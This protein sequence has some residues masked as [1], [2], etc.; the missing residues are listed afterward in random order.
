MNGGRLL[1]ILILLV[2]LLGSLISGAPIY[3]RLTYL[4]VLVVGVSWLWSRVSLRGIEFKRY[5]R[6]LR[7]S[8]GDVF[9]ERFEVKNESRLTCL[10]LEV[11]N[12]SQIPNA[13][14]S[15]IL[16]R[17]GGRQERSYLARTWL[18]LRGSFFLGPT[19]LTSGDPFG[20]FRTHKRLL[21]GESLVVMP[22]IVDLSSFLSPPGLLPGGRVIRRKSLDVT[23][24]ASGVREYIPGDPMKRIHWPTTVRRQQ[25][26]VKEF[27]QD[28]QAEVWLFLD[29]QAAVH[30]EKEYRP[31]D[32][33][34]DDWLFN[35]KPAFKLPPSTLEY[36][37]S[38]A[39]SLAHYFIRQKRAVGL[40]VAG[41]VQTIIPAERSWRQED[42]ILE[43]LA[44]LQATGEL[45][46]GSLVSAQAQQLPQGSSAIL[47]TPTVQPELRLAVD[48][49]QTREL[50]SV[51]ILL[52][53]DSFG[54]PE[55]SKRLMDSLLERN[56]P[57]CSV[58]YGADFS[59]ALSDFTKNA[60]TQDR[61]I[62]QRP[63]YIPL[64]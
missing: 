6:S 63:P 3:S 30:V 29:A 42:K 8:V 5:A 53:A 11:D 51:V 62:W 59:R 18:T 39:A 7:A 40:A 61:R 57:V 64:T 43:V 38:I 48:G 16:T 41:Q 14:G 15:R 60:L 36:S 58:Y 44:F 9:E 25:L 50:R 46:I 31:P 4:S 13:S 24:H 49:L 21:A 27:D 17:I 2:G 35:K 34:P 1:F 20:L 47:I 54:G 10:W 52:M 23:P 32:E 45:P 33:S 28:P 55:G 12:Q 37:I 26:M 22:M 56:V 19:V